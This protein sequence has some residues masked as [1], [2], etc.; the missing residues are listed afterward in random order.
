MDAFEKRRLQ[1]VRYWQGQ[2]LRSTDF[3]DQNADTAQHRWWHNRAL[4]DAYGV[5]QGL[6]V[7]AVNAGGALSAISVAPGLAYDC[8]GRE[9]LLESQQ[10]VALPTNVPAQ[11]V[12]MALLIGYSAG[13]DCRPHSN[14]EIC[15]TTMGSQ[16]S[17]TVEF[18]WKPADQV[19]VRDGVPLAQVM[20]QQ[21]GGRMLKH[22]FVP[23][24]ARPI[25]RA[26][27]ASGATLPETTVW[28]PWTIDSTNLPS[29]RVPIVGVRT[30]V[31]TSEAG[32]SGTPCYFAWLAGPLFNRDKKLLLPNMFASVDEESAT[33][34]TFRMW[35]PPSRQMLAREIGATALASDGVTVISAPLWGEAFGNFAR[36]ARQQKLYIQW[37]ACQ[38]PAA[39]PYLPLRL[40]LL[41]QSLLP[42]VL[43]KDFL[44]N[45][46]K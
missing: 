15:W 33:G 12:T 21:S 1:R 36:F 46:I 6:T 16:P 27:I 22:E 13:Q 39:L 9:L 4:H 32:F 29:E 30:R 34:F 38:M 40:R 45:L 37:L 20:Y 26:A 23:P 43:Q 10:T 28:M 24:G 3:R 18:F 44:R 35:F 19:T 42:Q 2:M 7:S 14:D 8:F 17:G 25:A 41:N 11:P 31:D 5:Y